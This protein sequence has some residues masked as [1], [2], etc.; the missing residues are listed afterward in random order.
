MGTIVSFA[1][2]AKFCHFQEAAY[3]EEHQEMFL[4]DLPDNLL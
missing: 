3:V 2:M 4:G 1:R